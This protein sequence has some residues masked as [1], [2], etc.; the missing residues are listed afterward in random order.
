MLR[1]AQMGHLEEVI[2]SIGN[3][4][5]EMRVYLQDN[6]EKVEALLLYELFERKPG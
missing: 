5:S 4:L 6:K 3:E 1:K 2:V